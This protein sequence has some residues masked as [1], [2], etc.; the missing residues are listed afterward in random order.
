LLGAADKKGRGREQIPDAVQLT[1][2][3]DQALPLFPY[4]IEY[5]K[6]PKG[7]GGDPTAL[8]PMLTLDF[9]SAKVPSDIDPA[10]FEYFPGD[11]EVEDRTRLFLE[12]LGF[13]IPDEK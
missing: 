4:R 6:A 13:Q 1:L 9:Y 2:G 5:L 11:Q 8:Q 10:Q 7:K 3:T 12:R